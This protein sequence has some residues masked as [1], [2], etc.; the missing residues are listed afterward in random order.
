MVGKVSFTALQRLR[1]KALQCIPYALTPTGMLAHPSTAEHLLGDKI[2]TCES[3][4]A[5]KAPICSTS[6]NLHHNSK[7]FDTKDADDIGERNTAASP[8][9]VG[10]SNERF[11]TL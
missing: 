2:A 9:D 3:V 4:E 10:V 6:L 1:I 7:T 11:K 5:R 8:L